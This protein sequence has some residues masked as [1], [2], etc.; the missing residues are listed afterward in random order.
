MFLPTF[1]SFVLFSHVVFILYSYYVC[2]I[3][4]YCLV[5]NELIDSLTE[6][7]C[8]LSLNVI[9]GFSNFAGWEVRTS[10]RIQLTLLFLCTRLQ[11]S[12][13]DSAVVSRRWTLVYGWFRGPK[14]PSLCFLTIAERPSETAVHR[15]RSGLP[16]SGC[17]YMEQSDL[18]QSDPTCH[19]RTL[20]LYTSFPRSPQGFPIQACL[21][22]TFTATLIL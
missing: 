7:Y 18:E 22:V 19:G 17:P 10:K 11:V 2:C 20:G 6:K 1:L 16:C 5:R 14:T 3:L 12:A 4:L 9:I 15:R 13:R 8:I 21:P